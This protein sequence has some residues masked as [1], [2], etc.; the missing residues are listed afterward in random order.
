M[1]IESTNLVRPRDKLT[2]AFVSILNYLFSFSYLSHRF[3]KSSF[4]KIT[5]F[6]QTCFIALIFDL[7]E[8]RRESIQKLSGYGEHKCK[9]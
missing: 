7:F 9:S 1:G 2:A 3:D 5:C 4:P 6:K 8:N